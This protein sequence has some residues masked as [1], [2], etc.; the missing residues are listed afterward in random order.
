MDWG[1]R[2]RAAWHGEVSNAD[3]SAMFAATAALGGLQQEL[4]SRQLEA[5]IEQT[6]HDWRAVL[7]VGRVAALLWLADAL[8]GVAGALYDTQTQAHPDRPSSVSAYTHDLVATL[9]APVEDILADATAA[10]ANPDHRTALTRPLRVGPGGDV[11]AGALPEPVPTLY[12]RGLATGARRVHTAA[13]VAV[14]SAQATLAKSPA[15]EWLT[16]GLRRLDGELQAAGARLDMVEVRLTPLVG[17][18]GGDPGGLAPICRDLWTI[19]D[20]A[21]VVGQAASDPHLLPEARSQTAADAGTAS[22]LPPSPPSSPAPRTVPSPPPV[23]HTHPVPLPQI[24]EG[25]FSARERP[26][27]PS[28]PAEGSAAA[29]PLEVALP[30]IGEGPVAPPASSLPA[31]SLPASSLPAVEPP[32]SAALPT[33]GEAA[34]PP[35]ADP[36]PAIQERPHASQPKTNSSH[37]ADDEP[38]LRFPEIG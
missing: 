36:A 6:G 32:G 30:S 26:D 27:M 10:L 23:H 21:V 9:L 3:L 19:M 35:G 18:H 5:Q 33:V 2:L 8:V 29:P 22:R 16:A 15:P 37:Q 31:S 12:A 14:A 1:A 17:G 25:S 7:E 13:A 20:T 28:P 11:A 34:Q 4:A 38:L 24:E